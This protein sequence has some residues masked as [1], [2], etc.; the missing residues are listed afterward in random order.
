MPQKMESEDL[1]VM[2]SDGVLDCMPQNN[3]ETLASFLEEMDVV[4]PQAVADRLFDRI[5]NMEEYK[6]KDDITILV[7][8]IWDR[9]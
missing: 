6:K 3:I 1:L 2:F 8:G 4:R 5:T 9:Y 7:L